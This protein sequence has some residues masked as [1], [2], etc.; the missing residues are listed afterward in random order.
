MNIQ[1]RDLDRLL[2]AAGA[3]FAAVQKAWPETSVT[4]SPGLE[5]AEPRVIP[6]HG[7]VD[8]DRFYYFARAGG[9]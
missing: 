3:G 8:H 2:E 9:E 1:G 7:P 4:P 5:M 6:A